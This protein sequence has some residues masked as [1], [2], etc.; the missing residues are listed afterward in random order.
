MRNSK[1][2]LVWVFVGNF[3]LVLEMIHAQIRFNFAGLQ[4]S[5]R[6]EFAAQFPSRFSVG[7]FTA[8]KFRVSSIPR[9]QY[10]R[11]FNKCWL[12]LRFTYQNISTNVSCSLLANISFIHFRS[13][14]LHCVVLSLICKKETETLT[15]GNKIS[16]FDCASNNSFQ[17]LAKYSRCTSLKCGFFSLKT[18]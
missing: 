6:N 16:P 5:A 15:H 14:A 1:S 18:R 2:V 17:F 7:K 9:V 12:I 8:Y 13:H 4:L 10:N 11:E 3:Q